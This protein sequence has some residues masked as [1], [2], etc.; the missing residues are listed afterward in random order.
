MK[1]HARLMLLFLAGQLAA[2]AGPSESVS[3]RHAEGLVRGFL[4]LRS[5]DGAVLANGDL[6]QSARGD[7]VTSRLVFHFK[8]GSRQEET[9]VYSERGRFQLLSDHLIQR[10]PSFPHPLEVS[11]DAKNGRVTIRHRE[12]GKDKV[13]EERMQ[14]PSDLANG[15]TLTLLKNIAAEA[16]STTVSMLFATPRPRLVKLVI[17]RAGEESFSVGTA[18]HEAARFNL[19]VEIGGLAGLI[20]PLIGKQ[21]HD[22]SVWILGGEAP[23]FVKSEGPFYQGGPIWRIELASPVWPGR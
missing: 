22:T 4:V 21:P 5:L 11:I 2:A 8:D 9:A 10:G 19:K 16:P 15:M 6:I 13:I 18:S 20:A 17:T 3:V 1:S 7:V 12:D 23:A 14:L